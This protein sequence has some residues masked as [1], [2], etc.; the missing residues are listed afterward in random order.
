MTND[1]KTSLRIVAMLVFVAAS[2]FVAGGQL[3]KYLLT[4]PATEERSPLLAFSQGDCFVHNGRL[5]PWEPWVEGQIMVVGYR[6]YLVMSSDA[7]LKDRYDG[8]YTGVEIPKEIFEEL[9]HKVDCPKTW[10]T[11]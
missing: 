8:R 6:K 10:R 11:K 3:E 5:E 1:T 2:S 4:R 7:R 9:Y